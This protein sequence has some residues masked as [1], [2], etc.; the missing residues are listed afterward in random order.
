MIT[1]KI[2]LIP[3]YN[4]DYRLS[5]FR[6]AL[7][8]IFG[9]DFSSLAA[10]DVWDDLFCQQPIFTGSGRTSLYVIL[11]SLGLRE[12]SH[13][14]V[15][16]YCCPVVFD[17][18]VQA[19]LIP[20]FIDIDLEDYNLSASDLDT[21]K[22]SLSAVVVVHMFGH[23]AKM[24]AIKA[25]SSGIPI[26]ED[27]AQSLFSRYKGFYTGSLATASFF[28]FRSGKYISAGEGSAIFC[29]NPLLRE[30]IGHL[31]ESLKPWRLWE[32]IVHCS[33]TYVKSTLY[34]RPWYGS[35]GYPIG[36]RL[37]QRLNLSAKMG[38]ELMKIA[39][40]DL[41]IIGD[42]IKNFQSKVEKQRYNSFYLLEN[43]R[44]RD[45]YLPR[46]KDGCFSNFY[47]F[48]IRFETMEQRDVV[49]NYLMSRGIDTAQYLDEIVDVGRTVYNYGGDCPNGER[50][51]KTTLVIPNHY[52]LAPKDVEYITDALNDS[53][54]HWNAFH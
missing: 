11:K 40:S 51:S 52:T 38:F 3:R 26:I 21:K 34:H 19:N 5:D 16:F 36:R 7:S 29:K 2:S 28:S 20:K 48:A 39:K 25:I 6:K 15:P 32:E 42:R 46:E 4:W 8:G 53:D 47:Q 45:V 30:S 24:D 31:A 14:G 49:A 23:P 33:A 54:E 10:N 18:I 35:I 12:G 13:V 41:K 1:E 27:C 22:E 9:E 50:C 43:L 37:D 44:L 17:A